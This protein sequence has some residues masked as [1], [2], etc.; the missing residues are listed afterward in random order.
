MI[1]TMKW[2]LGAI[3]MAGALTACGGGGTQQVSGDAVSVKNVDGVGQTLVDAS[4]KTLYFADQEA[5]GTVKCT[6]S[7]LSIWIPATGSANGVPDVS[8]KKRTDTGADQ[9]TYQG[10]PLYTFKLDKGA[11]EHG[12]NGVTDSFGGTSFTWHAA[13]TSGAAPSS[14]SSSGNDGD[15]GG[16]YGY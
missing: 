14:P 7:C 15:D 3:V 1:P 5:G 2:L 6:A 13:T 12:G 16:G 8:V 11:G 4:G 9:L 10:K